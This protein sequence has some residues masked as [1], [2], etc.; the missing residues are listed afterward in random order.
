[1]IVISLDFRVLFSDRGIDISRIRV[2]GGFY[3]F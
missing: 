2:R 1:M 3:R